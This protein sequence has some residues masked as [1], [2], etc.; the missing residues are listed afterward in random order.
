MKILR[1]Y[2]DASVI[3]G[4]FDSEFD[5]E[6]RALVKMAED[7]K[8]ILVVSDLLVGELQGAPEAVRSFFTSLPPSII[9]PL[10]LSEEADRLH[11]AY[12]DAGIVGRG[13]EDDAQHVANAT[14]AKVDVLVS[15]NMR[16]IVHLD[17][18]RMYNAVNLAKGYSLLSIYTPREVI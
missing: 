18:I 6:S 17:K 2:V 11:M 1:V 10:G 3:G 12:M 8:T 5:A 15:W 14:V 9:E 13:S 4:C 16:H 7:G